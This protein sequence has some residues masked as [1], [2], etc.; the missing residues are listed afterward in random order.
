MYNLRYHIASLVAVFL[1]L[2]IGLLLG[3]IV[4]ERGVLDRQRSTLVKSLQSDFGTLK[5]E[6]TTLRRDRDL[7]H[8]FSADAV[9][10]LTD[11]ALKGKTVLVVTNGGRNDALPMTR[12]AV[13]SAGGDVVVVT[14]KAKDFGMTDEGV[15]SAVS[16]LASRPAGVTGPNDP[17]VS[18]LVGEWTQPGRPQALTEALRGAGQLSIESSSSQVVADAVVLLA[19]FDGQAD[20][21]LMALASGLHKTGRPVAAVEAE[22]TDAGVAGASSGAGISSVDDVDRPQ[23][24][25]ALVQV[26]AAKAEGHFGVK[27]SA[28]AAYPKLR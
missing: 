3:T 10:V 17:M 16:A 8:A 5:Q 11:G 12:D 20:P 14:F 19:S 4:V 2:A 18:T 24:V 7:E 21:A 1:A 6:N 22:G 9:P 27:P 13:R 26:L 28:T 23:G 25:F 15:R